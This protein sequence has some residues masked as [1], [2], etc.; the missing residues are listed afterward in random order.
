MPFGT[1]QTFLSTYANK[2]S[3]EIFPSTLAFGTRDKFVG[4][5]DFL[6]IER[7]GS[8]VQNRIKL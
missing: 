3:I 2:R 6:T 4:F 7:K 1:K 5:K 8:L